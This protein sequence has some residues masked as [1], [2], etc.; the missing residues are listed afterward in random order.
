MHREVSPGNGE[1]SFRGRV[2]GGERD[3]GG[4]RGE[5]RDARERG[6]AGQGEPFGLDFLP[7]VNEGDSYGS[8]RRS[9]CFIADC[10]PGEL[11]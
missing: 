7:L 9:F 6:G 10:P 1:W 3:G 8:R 4:E 2:A 5:Y 11:R